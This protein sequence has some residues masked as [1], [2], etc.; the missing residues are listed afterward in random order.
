MHRNKYCFNPFITEQGHPLGIQL[1]KIWP[2]FSAICA[3]RITHSC[4]TQYCMQ[5]TWLS[6][7]WRTPHLHFFIFARLKR[8]HV[9]HSS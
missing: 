9:A 7:S 2:I 5:R 3:R 1:S 6:R 8:E 4:F